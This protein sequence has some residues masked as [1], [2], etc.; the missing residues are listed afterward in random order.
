[1]R[2]WHDLNWPYFGNYRSWS[3]V[4]C[5]T[6]VEC[7]KF[8]PWPIRWLMLC[9]YAL[10]VL[11]CCY[12]LPFVFGRFA[13]LTSRV[14][15]NKKCSWKLEVSWCRLCS[16]AWCDMVHAGTWPNI[17]HKLEHLELLLVQRL[18]HED[19]QLQFVGSVKECRDHS[20]RKQWASAVSFPPRLEQI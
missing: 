5:W 20:C 7:E 4:G 1:M 14:P 6:L 19:C 15:S 18:Q 3:P 13:R 2:N 8:A 10:F 11:V 12:L 17:V 16:D 9:V